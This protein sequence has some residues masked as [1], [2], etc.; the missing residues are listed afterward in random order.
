MS[1]RNTQDLG[2]NNLVWAAPAWENLSLGELDEYLRGLEADNSPRPATPPG[3]A[4]DGACA[5]RPWE[6]KRQISLEE[7]SNKKLK[8][9]G[10]YFN[11]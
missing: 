11:F 5:W 4:G 9:Q 6:T 3:N 8:T 1:D 7:G 10:D 2:E